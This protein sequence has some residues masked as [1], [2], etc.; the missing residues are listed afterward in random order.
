MKRYDF[1]AIL[2]QDSTLVHVCKLVVIQLFAFWFQL[3][4]GVKLV[5]PLSVWSCICVWLLILLQL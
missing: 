5:F 2:Y 4:R 1:M 3:R